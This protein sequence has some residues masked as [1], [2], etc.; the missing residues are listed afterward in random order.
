MHLATAHKKIYDDLAEEYEARTETLAPVT[1]GGVALFLS[2]LR[3]KNVLEIGSGVGLAAHM[4]SQQ[5]CAVTAVE[6]SP[7]MAA[8]I[9][10]RNPAIRV[11]EGD[12]LE[13]PF[14]ERCDGVFTFAFIHLFPKA[15]AERVLRKI[16][17]LL[18]PGGILLTGSTESPASSEGWEQKEDYLG[19]QKRFRKHWTEQEFRD[20][21]ADVGFE[22]LE[23]QKKT[24]PFG[25]T[26]LDFIVR[27]Y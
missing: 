25:K 18:R 5:G 3:G 19:E 13:L 20:T 16:K 21:F 17:T 23:L 4:L 24:D 7:N 11:I 12:F 6:L 15:E 14:E 26:W 27:Q 1:A 8:F 22:V 9:R 2:H 10:R